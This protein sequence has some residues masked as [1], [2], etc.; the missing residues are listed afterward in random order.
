MPVAV[1]EGS[2]SPLEFVAIT[3]TVYS[4][5][6]ASPVMMSTYRSPAEVDWSLSMLVA[7]SL[8]SSRNES[9]SSAPDFHWIL[10]AVIDA[11]KDVDQ[12]TSS[13]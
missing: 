4:V 5:P 10:N 8:E 7:G 11:P 9:Y 1:V 13:F 6:S 12:R 2:L 3:R